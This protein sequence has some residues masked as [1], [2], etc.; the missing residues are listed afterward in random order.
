M[1]T[2]DVRAVIVANK[3]LLQELAGV[4][5]TTASLISLLQRFKKDD[6]NGRR[7]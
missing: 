7:N 6:R 5:L 3:V 4:Y 2:G 1:M